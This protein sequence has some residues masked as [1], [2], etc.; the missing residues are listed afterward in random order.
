MNS[1]NQKLKL[2]SYF[3]IRLYEILESGG[4]E[5]KKYNP[6]IIL[7]NEQTLTFGMFK[8]HGRLTLPTQKMF[9][10]N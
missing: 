9:D 7:V 4:Y 2:V 8:F 3:D 5:I 6:K 1:S 10:F